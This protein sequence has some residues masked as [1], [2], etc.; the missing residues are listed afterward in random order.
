MF[1]KQDLKIFLNIFTLRLL[2]TIL[3]TPPFF[4]KGAEVYNSIC[5]GQM[6]SLTWDPQYLVPNQVWY[7][8]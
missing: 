6:V 5:P 2:K 7:S 8:L 1:R 3:N 4:V